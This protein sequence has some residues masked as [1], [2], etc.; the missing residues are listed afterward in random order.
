MPRWHSHRVSYSLQSQGQSRRPRTCPTFEK[1]F[2]G[3]FKFAVVSL[4]SPNLKIRKPLPKEGRNPPGVSAFPETQRA[5]HFA[6]GPR[7]GA[8]STCTESNR[9]Q[10]VG[11][12]T[13]DTPKGG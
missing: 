10:R 7:T 9:A 11:D 6:S 1:S 4:I 12:S 8:Q 2:W 5:V 13:R 3:I